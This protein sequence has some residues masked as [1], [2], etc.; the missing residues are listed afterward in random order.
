V[1]RARQ[2]PQRWLSHR[3][4][5]VRPAHR[6]L[7]HCAR[8]PFHIA[9]IFEIGSVNWL[10]PS[11][12]EPFP[13]EG[14]GVPLDQ[15]HGLYRINGSPP[16]ADAGTHDRTGYLPATPSRSQRAQATAPRRLRA[17][18]FCPDMASTGSQ[19]LIR[20]AGW[21]PPVSP[22]S[23]PTPVFA[24]CISSGSRE[25]R[26]QGPGGEKA[27]PASNIGT[28]LHGPAPGP[29][30]VALRRAGGEPVSQPQRAHRR[31]HDAGPAGVNRRGQA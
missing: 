25:G 13:P 7:R 28:A 10:V 27:R 20:A 3:S 31:G 6:H 23:P 16:P 22:L 4:L 17:H 21:L 18:A 11:G 24:P 12:E 15:Q 8:Y 30:P 14:Q 19:W 9:R 26:Y 29:C 2:P 5:A 1:I